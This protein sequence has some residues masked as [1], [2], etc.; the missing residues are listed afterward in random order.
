IS[1]ARF[2]IKAEASSAE[3]ISHSASPAPP[4]PLMRQDGAVHCEQLKLYNAG[5]FFDPR[6]IPPEAYKAIAARIGGFE[7]VIVECHPQFIGPRCLRF[8]DLL[9]QSTT[10]STAGAREAPRLEV[11]L[12]LETVHPAVLAKL[13]KRMTLE[14]FS[15]AAEFL[16]NNALALRVFVLI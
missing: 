4:P 6:A 5:S 2:R 9:A 15:R 8:R 10:Q 1:S 7:R 13:N 16:R 3:L 12:G 11:A 14:Q